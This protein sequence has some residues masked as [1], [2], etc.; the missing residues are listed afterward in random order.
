[1]WISKILKILFFPIRLVCILLI[2]LYQWIISPMLPNTCRFYPTCS[3]YMILAI[4]EWGI[5][6]GILLG[7][8]RILRCR[9]KGEC[10][11]DFV[12]QNIKGDSKWVY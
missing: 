12:P 10:G 1:M 2:K 5:I 3:N 6:K 8:K 7:I 4:K 11:E 9:P